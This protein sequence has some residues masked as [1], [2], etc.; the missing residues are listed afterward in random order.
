MS[1]LEV[2]SLK[3]DKG[4]L[5]QLKASGGSAGVSEFIRRAIRKELG[6]L[7][8]SSK[9]FANM[10]KHVEALNTKTTE[11]KVSDLEIKLQ[12]IYEEIQR[13]NEVL[14]LVHRRVTFAS[15]FSLHAVDELKKSEDFTNKEKQNLVNITTNELK[16]IGLQLSRK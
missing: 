14:A 11:Q 8:E 5:C 15:S 16:N 9:E 3:I 7:D 1:D 10:V 4:L 13:Q 6:V 12:I 2:I